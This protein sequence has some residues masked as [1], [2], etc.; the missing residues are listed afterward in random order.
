M[1]DMTGYTL[2][3]INRLGWYQSIYPDPEL[4][5]KAVE[6]TSRVRKGDDIQ[7]EEWP[8]TTKSGEKRAPGPSGTFPSCRSE[9]GAFDM[10]GNL[11]EWTD[12]SFSATLQDK[13]VKG[14]SW[15]SPDWASRCAYRYN[16]LPSVKDS[17]TGFRCCK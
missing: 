3:E 15:A 17:E 14:G 13:V 16:A 7:A 12:S 4:R 6:R 5:K 8:I 1:R 2:E 11:R 10:S 9:V